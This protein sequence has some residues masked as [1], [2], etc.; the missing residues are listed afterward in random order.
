[1][2]APEFIQIRQIVREEI[3]LALK[4]LRV[5]DRVQRCDYCLNTSFAD[6]QFVHGVDLVS[7]GECRR[8]RRD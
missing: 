7:G 5:A 8:T 3:R 4:E 1:M 6:E 2:E